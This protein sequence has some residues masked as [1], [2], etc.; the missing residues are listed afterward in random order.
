MNTERHP[1]FTTVKKEMK[2]ANKKIINRPLHAKKIPCRTN[3]FMHL[4]AEGLDL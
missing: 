4:L 2:K 3:E 1:K